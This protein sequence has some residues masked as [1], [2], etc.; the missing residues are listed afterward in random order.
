LSSADTIAG[1]GARGDYV[2]PSPGADP[3]RLQL[4]AD[5]AAI[6]TAVG[7]AARIEEVIGRSSLGES[8]VIALL[9]ALRA[10]GAIVPA[11]MVKA[12]PAPDASL[13]EEVDLDEPRKR[14]IL[15]LERTMENLN[16]FQVLGLDPWA[17]PAEVKAAFYAM[18][19][20]F[21]PD[22][23][24]S[25]NIGS[26]RARIE[27][28]FKRLSEAEGTLSDDDRRAVYLDANP[29]LRRS[30]PVPPPPPPP[31]PAPAA[32]AR[33]TPTPPPVPR[34]V[35]PPEPP[36]APPP[37]TMVDDERD[38]ERRARLARHPYV[39][40]VGRLNDLVTRAKTHVAKGEFSLAFADLNLA[41]QADPKNIEIQTMLGD[42][43]KKHYA[44]R[45][46]AEMKRGAEA[47]AGGDFT[48]AAAA[49][50]L[51]ATLDTTSAEA[52]YKAASNMLRSGTDA[53]EI[54]AFAQRAA[55]LQPESANHQG[56]LGEVLITLGMKKLAQRH[57][58]RALELDPQQPE[59]KKHLKKGRWPF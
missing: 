21:H 36:R 9:L 15:E 5:E 54:R 27:R 7:R 8:Q 39:A 19:R 24:F 11:R 13:G 6:F 32:V 26:Y 47:E 38:A 10:K 12:A 31:P 58:E 17:L 41:A 18:S 51:A 52:A 16:H 25:K 28:I 3:Q 42:V 55:D 45:A 50:R 37:R 34:P 20:K 40:R 30:R 4:S 23:Y 53:K 46:A 44:T 43:R 22:R 56:L 14:E 29:Y 33:S 49:Y 57:L 1:L 35:A 48:S 2:A 59:A